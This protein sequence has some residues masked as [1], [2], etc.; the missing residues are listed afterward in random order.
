[1]TV[2]EERVMT[3]YSLC[4]DVD[5]SETMV[6]KERNK[7]I[8]CCIPRYAS[9]KQVNQSRVLLYVN[10]DATVSDVKKADNQNSLFFYS[11]VLLLCR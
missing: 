4:S 8:A 10:I 1:V 6:M 5:V 3:K 7:T 11:M 2:D 9:Y